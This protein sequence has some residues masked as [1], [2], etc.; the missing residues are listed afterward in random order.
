MQEIS[1]IMNSY[2]KNCNA[3]E[4]SGTSRHQWVQSHNLCE[5]IHDSQ[6]TGSFCCLQPQYT[7]KL[8]WLRTIKQPPVL[9]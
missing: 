6:Y 8:E 1:I 5:T 3:M 9:H 7:E 4:M 2:Y